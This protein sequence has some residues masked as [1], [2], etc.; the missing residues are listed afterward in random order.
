MGFLIGCQQGQI[1]HDRG[2]RAQKP[3]LFWLLG[4]IAPQQLRNHVYGP[5]RAVAGSRAGWCQ[6]RN[7][8]ECMTLAR[9]MVQKALAP[10]GPTIEDTGALKGPY[11]PTIWGG[12]A[13]ILQILQ[14]LVDV[15]KFKAYTWSLRTGDGI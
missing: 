4:P 1:H 9:F 6:S 8:K 5:R 15:P 3:Y 2:M 11:G 14:K 10:Q 13:Y 12:L 7:L